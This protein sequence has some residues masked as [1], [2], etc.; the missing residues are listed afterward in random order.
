MLFN[1]TQKLCKKC[2]VEKDIKEFSKGKRGKLSYACK[3][4]TSK[5]DKERYKKKSSEI[6]EKSKKWRQEN[7][8]RY[9]K[10]LQ[11]WHAKHPNYYT[12]YYYSEHLT[13]KRKTEEYKTSK[14]I[15]TRINESKRR[16]IR[17]GCGGSISKVEWENLVKK[18]NYTCLR[19]GRNDVKLTLDHVVPLV[20]GGK[21]LIENAQPLCKSCN[22]KK[23]A[24]YID[25]RPLWEN[26]V[27]NTH[28]CQ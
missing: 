4:C 9:R 1:I 18:Y 10:S 27:V 13:Q 3:S 21:H 17:R 28:T 25:Y 2:G 23:G 16:A 11:D 19:C 12:E 22:S 6:K 7:K 15:H 5:Y 8:E 14:R 20:M 26:A 24:K